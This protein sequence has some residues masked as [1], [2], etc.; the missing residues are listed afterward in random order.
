MAPTWGSPPGHDDDCTRTAPAHDDDQAQI[1]AVHDDDRL[2]TSS[3]DDAV[4]AVRHRFFDLCDDG[5]ARMTTVQP[6]SALYVHV[7]FCRGRCRYCAFVSEPIVDDD[8]ADAVVGALLTEARQ[9]MRA[10]AIETIYIG[11]GRP[12]ALPPRRLLHLVE[13]LARAC[14]GCL[15]FTVE[16]HPGQVSGGLLS[17]LYETGAN[18]VSIGAQSF[19]PEELRRLGRTHSAA[20]TARCVYEARHAGFANV[21]LDL[22]SAIPGSTLDD[23]A[24]SLGCAVDL[25]PTHVSVYALSYE[26]GTE[27][28]RQRDA[29]R[30]E[31]VDEETDRAMM[32]AAMEILADAGFEHYEI[33]NFARPGFVCRHN[34]AYW[35][36]WPWVGVGPSAA[37]WDGTRRTTNVADVDDYVRRIT[38][39]RDPWDDIQT[40]EPIEIA[41]ETAVL[42]LRRRRGID[43]D[44]YR[45]VTGFD[46]EVL[47]AEVI[48]EHVAAGLLARTDGRIY[49]T[50]A[51]LPVAD[52]V[53][54][55]FAAP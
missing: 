46:A 43:L 39:G 27:L 41:C 40:L 36:N 9:R 4:F 14:P 37:S 31:P 22:I 35:A 6:A 18:R 1:S 48:A 45:R 13:S 16:V 51:G 54:C 55:D 50:P 34:L 47:F 28:T 19:V 3:V 8:R 44:D 29:G 15:E 10:D 26:P 25:E 23:L 30:L 42:N 5:L 24:H 7:P 49:L 53:L 21:S 32:F 33:S 2:R 12:T 20:D 38:D 11:G 17:A 52:R